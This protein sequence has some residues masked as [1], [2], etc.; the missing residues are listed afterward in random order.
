MKRGLRTQINDL[1]LHWLSLTETQ[2]EINHIMQQQREDLDSIHIP[3][4]QNINQSNSSPKN[5]Q[6]LSPIRTNNGFPMSPKSPHSPLTVDEIDVTTSNMQ[7]KLSIS[8][9]HHKQ[10]LSPSSSLPRSPSS[11]RSNFSFDPKSPNALSPSARKKLEFW[12]LDNNISHPTGDSDV[13]YREDSLESKK[14]KIKISLDENANISLAIPSISDTHEEPSKTTPNKPKITVESLIPRFYFPAGSASQHD[15][16]QD[17][18]ISK[19]Y[20]Y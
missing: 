16:K 1:F 19:V 14:K 13:R 7:Q 8:H 5:R 6:P 4:R 3:A 12:E 15:I 9:Q 18:V 10:T 2:E 11:G 17:M 20:I